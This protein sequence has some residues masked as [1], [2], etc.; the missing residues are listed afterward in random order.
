MLTKNL[1]TINYYLFIFTKSDP[2]TATYICE[3]KTAKSL[4]YITNKAFIDAFE[5]QEERARNL[6]T[7]IY[8]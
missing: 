4:S 8:G 5:K 7:Q 6:I 1:G 3:V 2:I